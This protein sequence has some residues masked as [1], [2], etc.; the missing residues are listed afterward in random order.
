MSFSSAVAWTMPSF[1][2]SATS[3]SCDA[4]FLD[5]MKSP[6]LSG[7]PVVD[8]DTSMSGSPSRLIA[9]IDAS[10]S[11]VTRDWFSF[12][13][14]RWTSTPVPASSTLV[15]FPT[16]TP[17]TRTMAPAFSPWTLAKLVLMS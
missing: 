16:S 6:S 4:G 13:I 11:L 14:D 12:L 9:P 10:E 5:L 2:V 3:D 17:A 15:T 1:A 7:V 8:G